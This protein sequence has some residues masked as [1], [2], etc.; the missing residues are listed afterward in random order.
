MKHERW[1]VAG[2]DFS[3]GGGNALA[4][5]L[6]LAEYVQ[7][8]VALVHAYEDAPEVA[9]AP[10]EPTV[11]L[12]TELAREISVCGAKSRGIHVEAVLRRGAPWEKLV[13]VATE[14]GAGAIVVGA[15]GQRGAIGTL[16]GSVTARVLATSTFPVLVVPACDPALRRVC[17]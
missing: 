6:N 2:T 8:R 7:A 10:E 3:D 17:A 15:V 14:L 16:I 13:N 9:G 12:L 1:I 4:H 11:R 5:A